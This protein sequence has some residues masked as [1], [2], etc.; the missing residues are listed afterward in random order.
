MHIY[1]YIYIRRIH[2]T[3]L[4]MCICTDECLSLNIYIYIYYM[5]VCEVHNEKVFM[6]V[7][8]NQMS[9]ANGGILDAPLRLV[10]ASRRKT[11]SNRESP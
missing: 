5:C 11:G 1:I 7:K 6:C 9:Y 10:I 2:T 4:Y 8:V 3:Y